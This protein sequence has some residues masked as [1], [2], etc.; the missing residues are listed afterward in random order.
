MRAISV[1]P[2][3]FLVDQ[4]P[5]HWRGIYAWVLEKGYDAHLEVC[6][7]GP[8][9][10][11]L[12]FDGQIK[13]YVD[14]HEFPSPRVAFLEFDENQRHPGCMRVYTEIKTDYGTETEEDWLELADPHLFDRLATLLR[15]SWDEEDEDDDEG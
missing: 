8:S 12:T 5:D 2:R 11:D 7:P 3:Q 9:N 4:M 6:D 15:D 13:V 1:I 14:R 10:P